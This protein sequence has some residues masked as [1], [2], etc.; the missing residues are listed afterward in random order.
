MFIRVRPG[1][2]AR[3][4]RLHRPVAHRVAQQLHPA[5]APEQVA[6]PVLLAYTRGELFYYGRYV[7]ANIQL[8]IFI[9]TKNLPT[10]PITM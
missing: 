8:N 10:S 3:L 7:V 1:S 9:H 5:E 6:L 2:D 4:P